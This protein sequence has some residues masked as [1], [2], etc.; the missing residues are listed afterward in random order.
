MNLKGKKAVMIGTGQ[1]AWMQGFPYTVVID[2]MIN[3]FVAGGIEYQVVQA[4]E[5]EKPQFMFIEGQGS[6]LHPAYPG[7]FEIIGAAKPD[8]IILQY[9][10]KRLDYDGFE[11]IRIPPLEKYIKVL[12]LISDRKVLA[13]SLN[14][15][16]IQDNEIE[17]ELEKITN[18]SGIYAFDPLGDLSG[19]SKIIGESI[20]Y[21]L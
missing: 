4:W 3:D 17:D 5:K 9:A 2:S 8:W 12:E 19:I 6:V 1:T 11:G 14:R 13:I 18:N 21:R 20:N 15:E 16:G 10:P 7:S